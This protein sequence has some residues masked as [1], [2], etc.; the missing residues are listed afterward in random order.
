VIVVGWGKAGNSP[1][2]CW[3]RYFSGK[4]DAFRCCDVSEP[5]K[6]ITYDSLNPTYAVVKESEVVIIV[7]CIGT[8]KG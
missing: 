2:F 8:Y 3:V 6:L 1:R 5:N 4:L 7:F